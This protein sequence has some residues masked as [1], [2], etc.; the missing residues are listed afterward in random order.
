VDGVERAS[1][2]KSGTIHAS[3]RPVL[4]GAN[5]SGPDPLEVSENLTG[6]VDEVRLFTRALSASE[7]AALASGP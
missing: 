5:A 3:S 2:P 6:D 4:I 1:G 7:V